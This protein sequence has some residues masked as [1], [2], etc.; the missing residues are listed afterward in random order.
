MST[1][2]HKLLSKSEAYIGG[3]TVKNVGENVDNV[4]PAFKPAP[5]LDPAIRAGK[6]I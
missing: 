6:K 1:I 3:V 2:P 4:P 5:M